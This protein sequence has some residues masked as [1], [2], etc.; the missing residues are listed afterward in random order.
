MKKKSFI[1][2]T[3]FLLTLGL[4]ATPFSAIAEP[5]DSPEVTA[6]SD[7]PS[8]FTPTEVEF[9]HTP[10][11]E[12]IQYEEGLEIDFSA[13][14][15]EDYEADSVY[16]ALNAEPYP[17]PEEPDETIIR[18]ES[19]VEDGAA[20]FT[21]EI[22][23]PGD[24]T[25]TV[26]IVGQDAYEADMVVAQYRENFK[27]YLAKILFDT[28]GGS[29]VAPKYVL[30]PDDIMVSM[31][32]AP[33]KEGYRFEG[34][35]S[36]P[37]S[38]TKYEETG[39]FM[40]NTTVYAHWKDNKPVPPPAPVSNDDNNYAEPQYTGTWTSPVSNG[41]WSPNQNGVWHYSATNAFCDAWGYNINPS[42]QPNSN[43]NEWYYFDPNGNMINGKWYYLNPNGNM[44][45]GWQYINGKWYFFNPNKDDNTGAWIIG[46]GTT[47][48][49]YEIDANGAWTGR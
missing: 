38:G 49:G 17:F 35:Y 29:E 44:L 43:N 6:L 28:Q 3:A 16:A 12:Y 5:T 48:D 9:T 2:I 11:G 33:T 21:M 40:E 10:E 1:F 20:S 13:E 41:S 26:Y 46:P 22:N 27:I 18:G 34:W 36:D 25:I 14:D 31:P 47:P 7:N 24:Y 45:T 19:C 32:T 37:T 15:L 23:R 42:L 39:S 4:L 8:E 30:T